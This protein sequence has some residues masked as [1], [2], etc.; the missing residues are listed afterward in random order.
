MKLIDEK[1]RLFGKVN[2]FDFIILLAIVLV[3]GGVGYKLIQRSKEKSGQIPVKNY[4]VTV[5]CAAMPDTF[6]KA[7][8]KDK[9]LYYDN[10]GFVNAKIVAIKEVPA[11]IEVTTADGKLVEA[12]S[13]SLNDVYVDLEVA[14]KANE[15]TI[16]IGRTTVSV[17]SKLNIK[18]IYALGIDG[19]VMDIKEK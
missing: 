13:P 16:K 14:D 5:K 11:V 2:I 15:E 6:S 7:L 10:D 4:I 8:E 3:V 1:G 17:G 9:R 18:T 19:V 12:E